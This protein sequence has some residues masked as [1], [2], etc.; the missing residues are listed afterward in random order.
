MG[1]ARRVVSVVVVGV[2]VVAPAL[3]LARL[4]RWSWSGWPDRE[5]L[6]RWA[7]DPLTSG[8]VAAAAVAGGWLLWLLVVAVV[9]LRVL[10]RVRAVAGWVRRMRL[11]TPWQATA[12]GL[13]GVAVLGANTGPV[14]GGV[15]DQPSA[16][17]AEVGGAGEVPRWRAADQR[18]GV[19][20]PGGWLPRGTAEQVAAAGVLLWLRRRRSYRPVVPG[21]RRS[22]DDLA[23]LPAVVAA[24]RTAADGGAAGGRAGTA[25][26]GRED[27]GPAGVVFPAG[28]V[29]LTGPGAGDAARGVLVTAAVRSLR[30]PAAVVRVVTTRADLEVFLGAG[31]AAPAVAGVQVASTVAD[32]VAVASRA[33][34]QTPA[35]GNVGGG[36][37]VVL[38]TR[39][40]VDDRLAEA[41]AGGVAVVVVGQARTGGAWE[42]DTSGRV[43]GPAVRGRMCV[44][45]VA[46]ARDV[47]AVVSPPDT[48]GDGTEAA[49]APGPAPPASGDA[50]ERP[51]DPGPDGGGPPADRDS[52]GRS[53]VAALRLRLLGG[54]GL[55]VQDTPVTVRRS[56]A[57]Q[58][59][60]FLA[61]HPGGG[62]VRELVEAIWPGAPAHRVTGRLYTTVS[63]LRKAIREA[64]GGVGDGGVTVVE[65][66]DDRYR[67]HPDLDVDLWRLRRAVRQATTAVTGR[68]AAWQAVIDL[69]GGCLADGYTWPW[70]DTPREIVRRDVIDAHVALA[71][72]QTD[73]RQAVTLLEAAI[74]VD[75][76]NEHLHRRA[77][78]MLTA[79][80]DGDT[81]RG[82]LRTFQ[83]RLAGAGLD[84]AT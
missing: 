69:Y 10:V 55:S 14:P 8:T 40:P 78:H 21:Q 73:P 13:A 62:T 74:R 32:A 59:L 22:D 9:L 27:D 48:A 53:G 67:L 15:T 75:P 33:A 65:H 82:L 31:A 37:R 16:A 63:D 51:A 38:L 5:G 47:L 46:A 26:D 34:G 79:L 42:V 49:F 41:A 30:D 70:L 28:G 45:D 11:P 43:Q 58:V 17:P 3:W 61:V 77:A 76:Y 6:A 44:L 20:V 83:D 35:G 54:V 52:G 24:A 72:T 66:V 60:V 39:G 80:G 4:T 1:W 2:L 12:T 19:T 25:A 57:L 64:T 84:P 36:D 23:P 7:A 56:A 71:D 50:R 18:V 29:G 68:P 81:A